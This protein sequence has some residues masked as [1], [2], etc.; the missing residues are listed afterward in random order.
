MNI[1]KLVYMILSFKSYK[2]IQ[3]NIKI[4]DRNIREPN[5][6][7]RQRLNNFLS[8]ATSNSKY[9][10]DLNSMSV[11]DF[12]VLTKE[13]LKRN[14]NDIIT[15]EEKQLKNFKTITTSGS[16]GT[17]FQF[18]V[19]KLKQ[20]I[21][22][23][24]VLYFGKYSNFDIGV[25]HAFVRSKA[26]S[27][28]LEL[29]KNQFVIQ[30]DKMNREWLLK[31]IKM[32]KDKNIKIL[33]GYPSVINSMSLLMK[34]E[35]ITVSNVTGI[36]TSGENLTQDMKKNMQEVFGVLPQS[37][38]ATEELGVIANEYGDGSSFLVNQVD[39]LVEVLNDRLEP[40]SE[41]ESGM[42]IVTDFNSDI[43]PLIRYDTG[44]IAKVKS[45]KNELVY[46]IDQL[47][48][49]KVDT[50]YDVYGNPVS[51]FSINTIMR[52]YSDVLQFQFIQYTKADYELKIQPLDTTNYSDYSEAL[53]IV[54]K[55][56]GDQANIQL[57]IVEKIPSLKSGKRPYIVNKM[58]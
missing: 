20:S 31:S 46:E 14:F 55:L 9:Y 27:F 39:F 19:T 51:A 24:Q 8:F 3:R 5:I 38:Y 4:L 36:I 48:G 54:S 29:I 7:N 33:I 26:A 16:T 44:D 42:V 21:R 2:R 32:I 41:G 12:P 40:V 11:L 45:Y 53:S 25:R 13:T 58:K 37:R 35:N 1:R 56:L 30:P 15:V 50:I 57:N 28:K 6:I 22:Q 43:I 47:E 23:A 18:R 10:N 34:E 49:R 17:P 52:E